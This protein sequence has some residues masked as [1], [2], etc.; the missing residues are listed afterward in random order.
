M[1]HYLKERGC[2][3]LIAA[4]IRRRT[5]V[6]DST[7]QHEACSVNNAHWKARLFCSDRLDQ[8][9]DKIRSDKSAIISALL[10]LSSALS[11]VLSLIDLGPRNMPLGPLRA[12]TGNQ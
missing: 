8:A 5:V 11:L 6:D 9:I 2:S 7:N 10:R 4:G 12:S 1:R 3:Y